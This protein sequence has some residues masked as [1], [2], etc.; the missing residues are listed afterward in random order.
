MQEPSPIRDR[1][2]PYLQPEP[3]EQDG[4]LALDESDGPV[5]REGGTKRRF[6]AMLLALLVLIGAFSVLTYFPHETTGGRSVATR[7]ADGAWSVVGLDSSSLGYRLTSTEGRRSKSSSVWARPD[8][9]LAC[10]RVWIHD[11]TGTAASRALGL[12]LQASLQGDA[13]LREVTYMVAGAQ[14]VEPAGADDIHLTL[15][16]LEHTERLYPGFLEFSMEVRVSGDSRPPL[17]GPPGIV[18]PGAILMEASLD[19]HEISRGPLTQNRRYTEV[20][21]ALIEVLDL[22]GRLAVWRASGPT[23]R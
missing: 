22:R 20:A 13:L 12:A 17:D 9:A 10:E 5:E 21:K 2:R 4:T 15:E 1:N 18:R 3:C 19:Y 8:H 16:V 6:L 11:R 23:A 7:G 14:S